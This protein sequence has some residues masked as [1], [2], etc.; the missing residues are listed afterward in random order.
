MI[1]ENVVPWGRSLAEYLGMFDL[2]EADLARS[3]LDCAGGPASFNAEMT[4]QNHQ[5]V[6]CD[7][8]YQFTTEQIA[9]RIDAVYTK[10]LEG[11]RSTQEHF[12]WTFMKSVEH[13]GEMRREAMQNFLA[14]YPT[15]LTEKRYI[16]G[17]LPHLPFAD[18]QFDL[19]LC[20]HFLF[21]YTEQLTEAFHLEALREM[22]RVASEVR[23]FP[24]L[25]SFSSSESAHLRPVMRV[26]QAEGFTTTIRPVPYEFQKGGNHLLSV[27]R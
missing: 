13:L 12:V 23:V 18:R 25:Q 8:I 26:L 6:S 7:P 10:M 19:V 11:T 15:G 22:C 1:L 14:D 5:V 9:A 21:T 16:P 27:T 2:S 4:R 20:S 24:L 3:I 17:E